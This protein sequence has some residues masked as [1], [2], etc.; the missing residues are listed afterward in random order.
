V[1]I[2][3]EG[4]RAIL[5][6]IEGTTTPL[7]FVHDTLFPYVRAQLGSFL[8]AIAETTAFA[9]LAT[10]LRRD[11]ERETAA[12][13]RPW[14]DQSTASQLASVEAYVVWLM[15][16]D[17]K[18]TPLKQLQGWIWRDGYQRGDLHGKVFDDVPRAF[19]AWHD[20]GLLTAIYS[21]GSVL[22]QQLLFANTQHG[23][24]TSFLDAYFDTT[25]GAKT[26]AA[27]YRRIATELGVPSS[28]IV[29]VSDAPKEL[30]AGSSAGLRTLLCCRPGNPEAPD[31]LEHPKIFSFD[32]LAL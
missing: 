29:F 6:D 27:S 28:T 24:L 26:E 13:P 1:R 31:D 4:A 30:D 3:L 16:A 7:S 18:S 32:E 23:D 12:P 19:E 8:P 20:A 25:T 10:R 21:S 5:L 14:N 9:D 17:R 22:A 2:P 11:H 15:D